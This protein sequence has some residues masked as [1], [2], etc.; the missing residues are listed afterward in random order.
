MSVLNEEGVKVLSTFVT[1]TTDFGVLYMIV[2]D[3]V[4]GQR[5]LRDQGFSCRISD[6]AVVV[7][8]DNGGV[9]SVLNE[10]RREGLNIEYLY[11]FSE[12]SSGK[13]WMAFRCDDTERAVKTIQD[14]PGVQ[15]EDNP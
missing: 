5:A 8:D 15:A 7:V 4:N 1:S 3:P 9:V 10:L 11:T 12:R 6:I 2:D 13:T 14:L